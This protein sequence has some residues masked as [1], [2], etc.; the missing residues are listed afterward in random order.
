LGVEGVKAFGGFVKNSAI[1]IFNDAVGAGRTFVQAQTVPTIARDFERL[2]SSLNDAQDRVI[3]EYKAGNLSKDDYQTRLKELAD[4]R[5]ELSAKARPHFE[6]PDAMERIEEIASTAFNVL[7]LGSLTIAKAGA[8]EIAEAG[9]KETIEFF[10]Q[11]G[12][13]KIESALLRNPAFK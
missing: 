2:S 13:N 11:Q 6:G 12:S 3:Q 4:A 8:K 9:G 1:D 5:R 10:L 7:S